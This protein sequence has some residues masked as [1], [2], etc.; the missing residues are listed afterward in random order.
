MRSDFYNGTVCFHSE[1]PLSFAKFVQYVLII[2]A[3]SLILAGQ[4]S[5]ILFQRIDGLR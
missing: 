1:Y 5:N 4:C 2:V 3:S